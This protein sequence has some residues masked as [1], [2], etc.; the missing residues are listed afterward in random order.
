[1]KLHIIAFD[2]PF[3]PDYGGVIDVYYK[4]KNLFEAGMKIYLHCFEYGR[5][6]PVEMQQYCEEVFYYKRKTG[7]NS[8]SLITPSMLY[9]RRDKNLLN[10]LTRIDAPILFEGV[11]TTYYLDHPALRDR[12]KIIRNQNLEQEYYRLL[13][14][15]ASDKFHKLYYL[16][17]S[18][19]LRR[20]ES[21]LGAADAFFTVAE[22][23]YLFFKKKYPG[24]DHE[25]IPS[26][27]PYNKIVTRP[28]KGTYC[29]YQG[30][31]GHPENE[32]AALF[33]LQ[34]ICPHTKVPFIFAGRRPGTAIQVLCDRLENCKLVPN[35]STI[36]MER[37][38]AEAQ[39]HI[40]PTFQAT[41]LKLK[42]LH[43]LFNGR[44]VVVNEEMVTGTG[45][46]K[47]CHIAH[48]AETFRIE[49]EKLMHIPF[50]EQEMHLRKEIVEQRYDNVHNAQRIKTYL[51]Q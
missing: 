17:E 26:F 43:A 42:L 44:H 36:E 10:N 11:H 47:A 8:I 14:Q 27:Q 5:G 21:K 31:L 22:H 13:A 4:I 49:V 12:K 19:L 37:L 20:K 51:L 32:E 40:L 38:I 50:D 3:P 15:R 2:V 46:E 1:M 45:L 39:V 35:P 6:E 9:S 33:L 24:K 48:N 34:H 25:Y 28:G 16:I 18:A 7:L 29:L 23:D 41:G 30:N